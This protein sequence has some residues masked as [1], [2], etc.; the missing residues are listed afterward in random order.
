MFAKGIYPLTRSIVAIYRVESSASG[1]T[2]SR[3]TRAARTIA[4][5]L[6]SKKGQKLLKELGFLPMYEN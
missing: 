3:E 4:Q 6:E 2:L 5:A 1:E